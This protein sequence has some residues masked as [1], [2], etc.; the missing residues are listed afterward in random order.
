MAEEIASSGV[1]SWTGGG[2]GRA[3]E[4]SPLDFEKVNVLM[5]KYKTPQIA[6]AIREYCGVL[7][8]HPWLC[9]S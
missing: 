8:T 5:K 3:L 9:A 2:E 7:V 1:S 4:M 6:S